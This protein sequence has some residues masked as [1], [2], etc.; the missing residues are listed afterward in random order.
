M[1]ITFNLRVPDKP[2]VPTVLCTDTVRQ[3][4]LLLNGVTLE[5]AGAGGQSYLAILPVVSRPLVILLPFS[6]HPL[7]WCP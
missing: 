6:Q 3:D 2:H 4:E 7:G 5:P 1:N